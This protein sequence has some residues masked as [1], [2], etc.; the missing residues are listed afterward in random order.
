[1]NKKLI[2]VQGFPEL[3]KKIQSLAND[4]V[5]RKEIQKILRL[6][7]KSTVAAARVEA[8]KSDKPHT[9]R[10]GKV[11]QPG[12]L[13]KSIKVAV[14]RR[15]RVPMVVVGPRSSGKYD[16]FYGRSF[17][18]PGHRTRGGGSVAPVPFIKRGFES[19]KGLVTAKAVKATE[20]YIQKQINRL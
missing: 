10:G 9:F 20:K 14:L 16:G 5:K 18:I 4:K 19:T 1:M 17:V 2:E 7:A 3:K 11:F 6:S 13:K 8:P 12:N 15:S